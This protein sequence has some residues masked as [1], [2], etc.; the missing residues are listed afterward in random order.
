MT[1]CNKCGWS[2]E[3]YKLHHY[4]GGKKIQIEFFCDHCKSFQKTEPLIL[5]W[6]EATE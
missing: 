3:F 5:K 6:E 1:A 4:V 2:L